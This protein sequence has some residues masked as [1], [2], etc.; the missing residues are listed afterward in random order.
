[1][2]NRATWSSRKVSRVVLRLLVQA[3]VPADAP[4]I[5]GIDEHSERRRGRKLAVNGSYRDP[6]RSSASFFVKTSGLRWVCRMLLAPIPW[7]TRTWALPFLSV[8]APS[9]RSYHER[10]RPH[11]PVLT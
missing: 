6:V 9:E 2:L 11:K 7:A 4:I 5:V 1:V 8:L 3:F 10:T